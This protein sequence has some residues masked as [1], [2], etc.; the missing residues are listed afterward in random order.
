MSE[1]TPTIRQ[2]IRGVFWIC[3]AWVAWHPFR[4]NKRMVNWTARSVAL[5][6]PGRSGMARHRGYAREFGEPRP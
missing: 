1:D 2:T 5:L 3:A 6:Y 4:S